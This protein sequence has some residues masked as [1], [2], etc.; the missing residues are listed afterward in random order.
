M[1]LLISLISDSLITFE[2][3]DF[4]NSDCRRSSL[5]CFQGWPGQGLLELKSRR[6]AKDKIMLCTSLG[7]DRIQSSG[8][9]CVV[10][11]VMSLEQNSV[12]KIVIL[13]SKTIDTKAR[14]I[15]LSWTAKSVSKSRVSPFGCGSRRPPVRRQ[16]GHE[17]VEK[18]IGSQALHDSV[19]RKRALT[20]LNLTAYER[21]RVFSNV[22]LRSSFVCSN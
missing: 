17:T 3:A 9:A 18:K 10:A 6:V 21:C 19:S 5:P 11:L 2:I 8:S 15:V 16:I 13:F 1:R 4:W 14:T 20:D 22:C 12:Y 7:S